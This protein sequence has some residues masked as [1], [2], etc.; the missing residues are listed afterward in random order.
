GRCPTSTGVR[1]HQVGIDAAGHWCS[2]D[3]CATLALVRVGLGAAS[4][5]EPRRRQCFASTGAPSAQVP[6]Q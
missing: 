2:V 3:V 1:R 4:A 5:L 6:R